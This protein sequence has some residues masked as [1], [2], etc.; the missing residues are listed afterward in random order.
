[1]TMADANTRVR[2][3]TASAFSA[4]VALTAQGPLGVV[5]PV[6]AQGASSGGQFESASIKT[7]RSGDTR[8]S[9]RLEPGGRY[10][11]TNIQAK[12]LIR[13]G[14]GLQ[15]FQIVDAPGWMEAERF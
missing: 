5:V 12:H 1:M 4:C 13:L 7:N 10:A 15:D 2:W 6:R 3:W 11:A 8:Q 14:Y 9:S